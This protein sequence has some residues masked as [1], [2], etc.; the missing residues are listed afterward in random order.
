MTDR[1]AGASAEGNETRCRC[2][3]LRPVGTCIIVMPVLTLCKVNVS[4]ATVGKRSLLLI[5]VV[6]AVSHAAARSSPDDYKR[7]HAYPPPSPYIHDACGGT[8]DYRPGRKASLQQD[9][10]RTHQV[11]LARPRIFDLDHAGIWGKRRLCRNSMS[12]RSA[13]GIAPGS[14]EVSACR[15]PAGRASAEDRRRLNY[16]I[17]NWLSVSAALRAIA[18][19]VTAEGSGAMCPAFTPLPEEIPQP[20]RCQA[21]SG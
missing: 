11:T 8:L 13:A 7:S 1:C 16:C 4:I 3:P 19:A 20:R 14:K 6:A 18:S 9:G 2:S 17:L 15:S 21:C 10:I 5:G 12:C